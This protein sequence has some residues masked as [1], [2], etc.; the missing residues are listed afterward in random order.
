MTDPR[1]PEAAGD[2][3]RATRSQPPAAATGGFLLRALD[4]IERIGNRLPHP[5]T[6]FAILAALVLVA[7]AITSALGVT[8]VHPKDGTLLAAV[9]LLDRDGVRRIITEAVRN[10]MGFAPLGTVLVAMIGIGVAEVTGLISVSMRAFVMSM[11]PRLLT[12]TIVFAGINANLAADAGIVILPPIGALLFAAAGRHPLAGIAA[13]FA[14]VAGGFSANLLPSSLD[15]LLVGFTQEA[16]TASRLAPGYSVQ[17]LGNYFFLAVSTPL[18]TVLATWVTHRFVEP[19]LGPWKADASHAFEPLTADEKRGLK[20]A[21]WALALT[22]ALFAALVVPPG[23][24]LR[25]EGATLLARIQPF[26]DSMVVLI[27]LLFFIPGTAYGIAARRIRSDHDVAKMTGDTLATM[28]TYILLAFVAAQFV[29]YFAW[30]NLGAILAISGANFLQGLGLGGAVLVPVFVLFAAT[31]NLFITSASAKWAILAPVFVP[32]FLLLGFTPEATQAIFRVGDSCTNI[33]T[34][35]NPYMPF[36]IA[37]A[38]RYAPKAGNGTMISLMLPY[39]VVFLVMWTAL[40]LVFY[41]MN[42]PIGPGVG[43]RLAG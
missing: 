43:M 7:S 38:Q 30:S 27:M 8:V 4:A 36:I 20:A 11:P 31:L 3:R 13:A 2:T 22:L 18:L 40:L 35:V 24:P 23:A 28:G 9:N 16:A 5:A 14:G 33:I 37:A 26:F 12:A 19:R 39:T 21:V 34:P 17:V 1:A 41:L 25:S 42:W 10:F 29:S 32:M 6:L 15:V